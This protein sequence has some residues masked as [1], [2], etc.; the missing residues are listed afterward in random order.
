MKRESAEERRL[1][2]RQAWSIASAEI[3]RSLIGRRVLAGLLLVG[4]PI[5]L[6]L[7]R[8][9]FM[10]ESLRQSPTR[11][12]TEF[13]EV[14]HF[15]ILRFVVFFT[16]A[17]IFVRLFRGEILEQ[18]LHYALLAPVSRRLLVAAKYIGGLV[19]AL[20]L[21][22]PA[23]V[24][25][26]LLVFLPHHDG[27][28]LLLS[29]MTIRQLVAYLWMV[30]LASLAYGALFLLAGLYFKNPMVPAVL[31]LG[32]E[33]LTP[34]LPP[35]LKYLSFVHYLASFSPVPVRL[36]AFA[37]MAQPVPP[38][39][40]VLALLGA[41]AGLVAAASWVARRLEVSYAAD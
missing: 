17:L 21:L 12:V 30:L 25:T 35:L 16:N 15:F 41:T 6:M 39:M 10:P 36:R 38:W 5:A 18:T 29:T 7:L 40:A 13:A 20:T 11:A 37:L 24:I 22:V 3:R 2:R 14:F 27:L 9:V 26:Y 4:M 23:T 34:F 31:F 33:A 8:A 28:Q 19:T 1:R 32:W